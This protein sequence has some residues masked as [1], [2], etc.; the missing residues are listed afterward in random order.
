MDDP[1]PGSGLADVSEDDV[2]PLAARGPSEPDDVLGYSPDEIRGLMS[3]AAMLRPITERLLRNAGLEPG[4]RVLDVGCGAGDVSML[5][6]ELVG[7]SGSVVGIDRSARMIA[8]A[9]R[10][11]QTAHLDNIIFQEAA[12]DSF[13]DTSAFDCVVGRYVL[14]HQNDPV[15]FLRAAARCVKD[16]GILALHEIDVRRVSPWYPPA[17]PSNTANAL[18]DSTSR[19]RMPHYDAGT[20]LFEHFFN[21]G[22]P[23]P[24][25]G[26]VGDEA[27]AAATLEERFETTVSKMHSQPEGPAQMCAWV[28]VRLTY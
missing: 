10:R 25:M 9:R 21:A 24:M 8:T 5:A 14:I 2:P 12:L 22:L 23:K 7:P 19:D 28:R 20:R 17:W 4:M 16:G 11:A 1:T 26:L 18:A 27:T 15:A 13:E 6:A 3:Q